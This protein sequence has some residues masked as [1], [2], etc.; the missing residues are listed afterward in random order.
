LEDVY[1]RAWE[2]LR[3]HADKLAAWSEEPPKLLVEQ[4]DRQIVRLM[5]L[6]ILAALNESALDRCGSPELAPPEA[7]PES[8]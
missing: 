5:T 3:R 1:Q 6:L 8:P 4:E 7:G 2:L